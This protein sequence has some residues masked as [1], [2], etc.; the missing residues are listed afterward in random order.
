MQ[1]TWNCDNSMKV[2]SL[3]DQSARD[4]FTRELNQNFCVSAGAGVGKTTAIVDRIAALALREPKLLPRLVVVTYGKAAAEELKVRSRERIL[5]ELRASAHLRQNLLAD[6]RR[7]FF[8]TIHSFCL[9]LVQE[10]GRFLGLS[11]SLDLLEE[12]QGEELWTRFTESRRLDRCEFPEPAL[13]TVLRFL[14]FDELLTL[15][16]RLDPLSAKQIMEQFVDTAEP[17]LDFTNSLSDS[18]KRSPEYTAKNQSEIR[19]WLKGFAD[20]EPFLKLPQF[21]KGTGTFKESYRREMAP[22]A[23]WLG[24]LSGRIAAEI[25]LA[26]HEYRVSEGFMTYEDQITWCRKLVES[27]DVLQRLRAREYIVILDEAQDTDEVMFSILT[28][29]TRPPQAKTDAWPSDLQSEGPRPGRFSF[30]GDEQQ[31]IYGRANLEIYRKYVDAYREGSGGENLEF[32]V[33][34]RCPRK[35]TDTV[36]ALFVA[37]GRLNQLHVQFR[38]LQPKPGSP[39]GAAWRLPM[40]A[41]KD[42]WRV[43][44]VFEKECEQV[45]AFLKA[46]GPA[47]LGVNSWG[48]VAILCPRHKWLTAAR[49]VLKRYN[50]PCR[51]LAE[52]RLNLEVADRSWPA[53][54]LHV[55]LNP[56]DRFELIGVLR[57]IFA[58]SDVEL[59]NA[60]R[61]KQ[62][63][64][65]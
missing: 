58:V 45:A 7:A 38:E 5:G 23:A 9:K 31:A 46:Y 33:T 51:S 24:N 39:D 35:V 34:M 62:L 3:Q 47:G 14:S 29:I 60:H 19:A 28:E 11:R 2:N 42:I 10:Q 44:E 49:E 61:A 56:Y 21:D 43:E 13:S 65:F 41:L 8:G 20:G 48:E 15:A 63:V 12:E 59:A 27:P 52:K 53:A 25:S 30:V 22:F 37:G 40:E 64:L 18:G 17:P 50:V 32:S 1:V 55:L 36:N 6:L 54:L 57:E 4:R 16:K 26:Y